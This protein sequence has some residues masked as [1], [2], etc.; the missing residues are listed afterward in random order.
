MLTSCGCP[1]AWMNPGRGLI[2]ITDLLRCACEKEV[3]R[4]GEYIDG[5]LMPLAKNKVEG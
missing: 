5:F 3:I 1:V 2:G 4:L